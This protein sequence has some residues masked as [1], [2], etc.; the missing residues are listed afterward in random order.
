MSFDLYP[1]T[2]KLYDRLTQAR[3]DLLDNLQWVTQ[4]VM[5][6]L[7][8]TISSRAPDSTTAKSSVCTEARLSRLD[9]DVRGLNKVIQMSGSL[10]YDTAF[11]DF[12][13]GEVV[14]PDKCTIEL[15]WHSTA[16]P[17]SV[18][19]SNA[20]AHMYNSTTVRV[21]HLAS[22]DTS[23]GKFIWVRVAIWY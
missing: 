20:S 6:R 15:T 9:N 12:N 14:D 8:T 17:S 7:D 11:Q 10:F 22:I 1:L 16:A 13:L 3:A 18:V 2:K 23:N 4:S 5:A 21:Q 19:P